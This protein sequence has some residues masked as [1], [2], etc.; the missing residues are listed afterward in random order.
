MKKPKYIIGVDL[1][2]EG[3]DHTVIAEG[4]IYPDGTL[5]IK[6]LQVTEFANKLTKQQK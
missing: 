2:R 1:G 6:K 5:K 3:A 4:L